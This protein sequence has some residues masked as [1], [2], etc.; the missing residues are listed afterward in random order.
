MSNGNGY[1]AEQLISAIKEA[2]GFVTKAA[3]ILKCSRKTFY[4]YLNKYKTAQDALDDTREKRHE[5]VESKLMKAIEADNLTAIIF[6][7]KT[8]CKHLG[9]VERQEQDITSA[10]KP[11]RISVKW[12]EYEGSGNPSDDAPGTS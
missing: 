6:Y 7:L 1:T 12:D 8:Q 5:W 10:G 4:V 11:L 2:R 9:Y 3:D